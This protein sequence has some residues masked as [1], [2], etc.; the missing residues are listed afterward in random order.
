[1]STSSSPSLPTAGRASVGWRLHGC[2]VTITATDT[3]ELAAIAAKVDPLLTDTTT[4]GTL[5][6]SSVTVESI[7]NK[8]NGGGGG[9]GGG[10]SSLGAIIGGA[11]GGAVV[12]IALA[13]FVWW[14]MK[15]KSKPK[16]LKKVND[17]TNV[18]AAESVRPQ[19][20]AIHS[21][22]PSPPSSVSGDRAAETRKP[23]YVV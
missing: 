22:P 19:E 11:A 16:S 1:M 5:L 6:G 9:E 4:A 14:R 12:L 7:R 23:P 10:G 8:P 15:R 20:Q 21:A 3:S 13:V 17:I 2:T 18:A